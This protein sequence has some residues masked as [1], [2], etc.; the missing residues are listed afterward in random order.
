MA[1]RTTRRPFPSGPL[2]LTL[3][4][5]VLLPYGLFVDCVWRLHAGDADGPWPCQ[6]FQALSDHGAPAPGPLTSPLTT[7]LTTPARI[8]PEWPLLPVYGVLRS[9]TVG[10]GPIS[11]KALGVA[12]AYAAIV[13]PGMAA[14]YDWSRLPP[15]ALLLLSALAAAPVGVGVGAAFPA[16]GLSFRLMQALVAFWFVGWLALWPVLARPRRASG[17]SRA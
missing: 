16:E 3:V 7:P 5:A 11:A 15:R 14:L 8:A 13:A 9:V 12:A 1:Q 4:T 17:G 10:V 2:R 6:L